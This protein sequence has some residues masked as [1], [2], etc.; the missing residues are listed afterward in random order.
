MEKVPTDEMLDEEEL[1]SL[2]DGFD[3][4]EIIED[5]EKPLTRSKI[6]TLVG[7]G[8]SLFFVFLIILFPLDE[9][10]KS[11]LLSFSKKSGII[12]EFKDI[13]FPIFGAKRI[14]SLAIQPSSNALIKTEELVL[15]LKTTEILQY[16]FDGELQLMGLKYEGTDLGF[17]IK[18][19]IVSGKLSGLDDRLSRYTGDITI[20]VRG[21]K[22][23]NLP[24]LP[25]IGEL[26][27]DIDILQG[28]FKLKFRTGKVNIEV[29][30]LNT[31]WLRLSLSGNIRLNDNIGF[32]GLDLKVCAVAQEKFASERPDL[33]GML[34][35]L[36][37]E[38]GRACVPI[39]GTFRSPSVDT[40][41]LMGAP[42]GST[43]PG[44]NTGL[45]GEGNPSINSGE[46]PVGTKPSGSIS[47]SNETEPVVKDEESTESSDD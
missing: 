32:S 25:L 46:Q 4:D 14:D 29:G 34:V 21:G 9:V 10:I 44:E 37:Q 2:Q 33:A 22:I 47:G 23:S 26:N 17:L 39:Q 3:D 45:D 30:N 15:D 28:Q 36:P 40:S 35:L 11:Y 5:E 42:G 6:F 1:E 24:N 16:R 13:H 38:N 18:S 12:I 19:I 43:I 7:I 41:A 27:K 20:G 8:A 31:S